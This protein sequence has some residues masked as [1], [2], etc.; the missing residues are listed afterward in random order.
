MLTTAP[1]R[2]ET[3]EGRNHMSE[4][5]KWEFVLQ[6]DHKM[7]VA[8]EGNSHEDARQYLFGRSHYK[9]VLISFRGHGTIQILQSYPY[10]ETVRSEDW[11]KKYRNILRSQLSAKDPDELL[12]ACQWLYEDVWHRSPGADIFS[13][14]GNPPKFR[15]TVTDNSGQLW[16]DLTMLHQPIIFTLEHILPGGGEMANLPLK[17]TLAD[18]EGNPINS[19]E[20]DIK[21]GPEKCWDDEA[22]DYI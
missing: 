2:A 15:F 9:N 20:Y 14:I 7:I 4:K 11:E 22:N 6:V 16:M 21:M 3:G 17:S 12:A 8:V 5:K 13:Q 10:P 18:S 19:G 1:V